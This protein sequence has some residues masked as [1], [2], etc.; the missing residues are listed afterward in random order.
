MIERRLVVL[1]PGED[2]DVVIPGTY[3]FGSVFA[4]AWWRFKERKSGVKVIRTDAEI[5][6]RGMEER[7]TGR[8]FGWNLF[9]YDV[10]CR[11]SGRIEM[12]PYREIVEK[13]GKWIPLSESGE[14][15]RQTYDYMD[16]EGRTVQCT[17]WVEEREWRRRG[18]G[19]LKTG[20]TRKVDRTLTVVFEGEEGDF[21]FPLMER[22][23]ARSGIMRMESERGGAESPEQS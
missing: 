2:P 17:Y 11:E 21:R 4:Y 20:W 19:W 15:N 18:L 3:V 10:E 16:G 12:R 1:V 13:S 6:R 23:T 9:R 14:V 22:E 5:W 8:L 7:L